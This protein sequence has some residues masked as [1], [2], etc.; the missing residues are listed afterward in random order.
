MK[1]G[2]LLVISGPSG[3]G[4]GTVLGPLRSREDIYYSVSVT[5]RAPRDGETDGEDYHFIDQAAFDK[6]IAENGLLEY[7]RYVDKS[8][9]TP[10]KAVEEMRALG[11][12]VIL[13]IESDG[14]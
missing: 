8:Y 12:H 11:K 5:T 4:K 14:A 10:R 7:A 6:L 9:G 1:K 2:S 3:V 13:E